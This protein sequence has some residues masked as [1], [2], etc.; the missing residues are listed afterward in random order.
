MYGGHIVNDLDRLLANTYLDFFMKDELLDEMPLYPYLDATT[1][2]NSAGT[3]TNPLLYSTTQFKSANFLFFSKLV[4]L[5]K[6]PNTNCSYDL[7]V[8]HIDEELKS[9]TPL[10]FGLHPNA[11][12]GFRTQTSEE[13]LKTILE[14]SASS[15]SADGGGS[16]EVQ[17]R[18]LMI[19]VVYNRR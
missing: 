4:E 9:E 17:V 19:N 12:I 15:A 2:A 16:G 8:E 14:L 11:E 13:L 18:H 6:A 3:D 7:V 10:A 1:A 5:F